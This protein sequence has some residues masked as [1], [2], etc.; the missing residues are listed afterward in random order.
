MERP[1]K[2]L[3]AIPFYNCE[4]Q[5]PRVVQELCQDSQ[6]WNTYQVE[7]LLI[8]NQSK[9]S[10]LDAAKAAIAKFG[11]SRKIRL[12]R[13]LQNIG[14]GGSQK[15]AFTWAVREKFERLVILHGDHQASPSETKNLLAR[16]NVQTEA[17]AVLG[18]RFS[19]KSKRIGYSKVRT[20]GNIGLNIIYTLLTG[21][22]I[23]DLGSGLNVFSVPRI[24]LNSIRSHS[25][26]FT[27]NM[28][29]LLS[30]VRSRKAFYFYP[31]QWV[32]YDQVSNA[33]NWVVGW[34][35][36]KTLVYWRLHLASNSSFVDVENYEIIG[37]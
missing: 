32:E 27:F 34:S 33:R 17:A 31:I 5:L 22:K 23:L 10:S 36:F 35:A 2:V 14:L 26:Q 9:D 25:N 3:I 11:F 28:D 8:D 20:I 13:N 7:V 6:I 15:V 24:D 30:F 21:K 18:T 4:K 19:R 16:M 12:I 37:E 29:L 1:L